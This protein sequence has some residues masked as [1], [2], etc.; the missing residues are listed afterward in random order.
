MFFSMLSKRAGRQFIAVMLSALLMSTVSTLSLA[1]INKE[2]FPTA[3][4]RSKK[5]IDLNS[6]K[7]AGNNCKEKASLSFEMNRGQY[8]S[9]TKFFAHG[10]KCDLL[11]SNCQATLAYNGAPGNRS[12]LPAMTMQ[13]V[14][15][16]PQSEMVGLDEMASRMNYFIG[17]DADK[18][19]TE[20]ANFARVKCRNIYS[21]ID[22]IYY[23][24]GK[25]LEYD[26]II[27]AGADPATIKLHYSG[28][29]AISINSSG[30]LV[31]ATD[32]GEVRQPAPS[33]Y[34]DI[35]G[36]RSLI[37]GGYFIDGNDQIGFQVS[38][39]DK[40]QALIIDP[41]LSYSSY[42]GG[43]NN[44]EANG[45]AVDANG[46]IYLTGATN[47]YNFPNRNAVQAINAG[48]INDIFIAKFSADGNELIYATYLGGQA[49]DQALAIAVD[50]AGNAYI[51]GCTSSSDFPTMNAFQKKF[52][53]MQD[54]FVTKLNP[55]G[56]L[57]YS[58]YLG[59]A[60]LDAG[61]AIAADSAGNAYITGETNSTNFPISGAIQ[62]TYQNNCDLFITRVNTN[63]EGNSSLLFSSY[64]GGS[65]SDQGIAIAAD[66]N[67]NAYV[68]GFTTSL[69]FP[70]TTNAFQ[71]NYGTGGD[72]FIVKVDTNKAGTGSDALCYAS[73][74]G[75]SGG[76][77]GMG[78]AID[79]A[80]IIYIGGITGS[81]GD[82]P[83]TANCLQPRY[84][85]GDG[86]GFIVKMDLNLDGASSLI[87][88]SYFGG[89]GFD[90]IYDLAL[91]ASGNV[92]IT[93][94][95]DSSDLPA[96]NT[97]PINSN[98]D[99]FIAKMDLNSPALLYTYCIGG[100]GDDAGMAIATDSEANVY[101]TGSTSSNDLPI[102][103]NAFQKN[104]GGLQDAFVAKFS[105]PPGMIMQDPPTLIISW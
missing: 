103:A 9:N 34:Q 45:I 76:D 95:A 78:I 46:N 85:G 8:E 94:K 33:I 63:L 38:E 105:Q 12:K 43:G 53:G 27:A 73:F 49:N 14:G 60:N 52:G 19:Q 86:D 70:I 48:G 3:S 69:D 26:F 58:S 64:L 2:N 97:P 91:D 36:E 24:K 79:A 28:A 1:V 82:F 102:T 98:S 11:L 4:I 37:A 65:S 72:A 44:D 93:G 92:Y 23:G 32:A 40:K 66:A 75:G 7:S 42:L 71:K 101:I 17:N 54:G 55:D 29:Q 6:I 77:A 87:Y 96:R 88:A 47:S 62:P 21:G 90:Q 20:I 67:G 61:F 68:T 84:G 104:F 25:Q 13:I 30:E 39:Y 57:I 99:A 80:G 15:A 31:I 51:T 22:L 83:V 41:I 56:Q 18:W 35:D 100:S 5:P 16:D 89:G 50:A 81:T 10:F 59:G 74:L